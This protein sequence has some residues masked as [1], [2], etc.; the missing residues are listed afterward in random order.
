[1]IG[2]SLKLA[3]AFKIA[4]VN[5]PAAAEAPKKQKNNMHKNLG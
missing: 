3:I 1:M 2:L 5:A 4:G